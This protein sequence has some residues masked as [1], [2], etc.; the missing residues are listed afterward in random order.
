MDREKYRS[1]EHLIMVECFDP[2][3]EL[4]VLLEPSQNRGDVELAIRRP[5]DTSW[6]NAYLSTWWT[7]GFKITIPIFA[8]VTFRTAL[9]EVFF[10][11][12]SKRVH[13]DFLRFVVFS[14]E[15]VSMVFLALLFALGHWGPTY[16]PISV[17]LVFLNLLAGAG[18]FTT[19]LVALF[20]RETINSTGG[21]RCSLWKKHRYLIAFYILCFTITDFFG[22]PLV[23][24]AIG[25]S[26]WDILNFV[27]FMAVSVPNKLTV[28]YYFFKTAI[29]VLMLTGPLFYGEVNEVNGTGRSLNINVPHGI[30][31]NKKKLF[32]LA[33]WLAVSGVAMLLSSG[34]NAYLIWAL[35]NPRGFLRLEFSSIICSAFA[36]SFLRIAT[37]YAQVEAIRPERPG[38]GRTC[39]ACCGQN[40]RG[41]RRLGLS[42]GTRIGIDNDEAD[43]AV[44]DSRADTGEEANSAGNGAINNDADVAGSSGNARAEIDTSTE[45]VRRVGEGIVEVVSIW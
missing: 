13:C 9:G 24:L 44:S 33:L 11:V 42:S 8:A 1:P 20:L 22:L 32:R 38:R 39:L 12:K 7:F 4:E 45:V 43:Y 6:R 41:R 28:A 40:L 37:S 3:D 34:L 31:R 5:H 25:T 18:V 26:V 30:R 14:V 2:D 16:L 15:M 21:P 35:I 19:V 23:L 17:H 29:N 36:L 10:L 27:T